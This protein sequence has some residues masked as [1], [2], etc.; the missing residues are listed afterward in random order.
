MVMRRWDPSAQLI[1]LREAMD[2]LLD[3]SFIRPRRAILAELASAFSVPIDLY[4]RDGDYV[5]KAFL[6]GAKAEDVDINADKRS[7]T[8]KAHIP[9]EVEKEQAKNYKWLISQLGYGD[10]ARTIT[11][12]TMV[13]PDKIEAAMENGVLTVTIPK[14][15]EA[16]VKKIMV[17]A[18]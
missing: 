10:V 13:D 17:E 3:Q 6:P 9:G 15:D 4:E 1:S 11:L 14:A 5:I 8:I 2:R 7:V 12:P 18:K 16:E